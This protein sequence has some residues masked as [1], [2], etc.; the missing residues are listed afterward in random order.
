MKSAPLSEIRVALL[1]HV[2]VGKTTVLNAILGDKFGEVSMRRTTAGINFFRIVPSTLATTE[3]KDQE[4]IKPADK[5]HEEIEASNKKLR[6]SQQIEEKWFTIQIDKQLCEMREKTSLVM[7]DIPGINE[8]DTNS[9]YMNYVQENWKD[10][11]CVIVIMDA[12]QGVNTEEQVGLLRLVKENLAAKKHVPVI[13]MFNK[14]DDPDDKEQAVLVKE[15]QDKIAKM[16]AVGCRDQ[17]LKQLP[18]LSGK[19]GAMHT[20]STSDLYPIVIPVSAIRAY[21]YRAASTLSYDKFRTKFD[22][23]IV[24]KIGREEFGRRKWERMPLEKKYKSLHDLVLEGSE[25]EEEGVLGT[26]FDILLCAL[27]VAVGGHKTQTKLLQSQV[28]IA[29]QSIQLGKPSCSMF[30]SLYNKSKAFEKDVDAIKQAFWSRYRPC[31]KSSLQAFGNEPKPELLA[32][33]AALLKEYASFVAAVGW[34][35]E[36]KLVKEASCELVREQLGVI[37]NAQD[38]QAAVNLA[39]NRFTLDNP[40]NCARCQQ[41]KPPVGQ[42]PAWSTLSLYDWITIFESLQRSLSNELFSQEL[43]ALGILRDRYSSSLSSS[44]GHACECS[45]CNR[46]HNNSSYGCSDQMTCPGCRHSISRPSKCR[47]K[48]HYSNDHWNLRFEGGSIKVVGHMATIQIPS[49][50][51]DENHWGHVAW[52]CSSLIAA[53]L[54]NAL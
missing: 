21:F 18:K 24:D 31:A 25:N 44:G 9:I 50:P 2:S 33:P 20:V 32:E 47:K 30:E 26:G 49:L 1:G 34:D 53:P 23:E 13:V 45:S 40:R 51:S 3:E 4:E 39:A 7:V 5:V 27:S 19:K 41:K 6:E 8:A 12:R 46:I 43:I 35:H 17:A 11:D 42:E 15:S 28:D 29:L 38:L 10:F 54:K 52:S 36:Q 37:V 22:L 16:F 14:V 48:H